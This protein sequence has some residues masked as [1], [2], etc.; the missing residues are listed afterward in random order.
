MTHPGLH[1]LDATRPHAATS[2]ATILRAAQRRPDATL[3]ALADTLNLRP[4]VIAPLVRDLHAAGFLTADAT[5]HGEP[6]YRATP[7]PD[8]H[9]T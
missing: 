6:R 4:T 3:T 5:A 7:L 9:T 8:M 1:T 2:H